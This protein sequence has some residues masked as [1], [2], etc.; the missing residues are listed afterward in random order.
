MPILFSFVNYVNIVYNNAKSN[1]NKQT[2]AAHYLKYFLPINT[3]P[4]I[5][6]TPQ[7]RIPNLIGFK[8]SVILNKT[9]PANQGKRI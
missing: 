4:T 8:I 9:T 1:K 3:K 6:N 2:Q 5:E 7:I